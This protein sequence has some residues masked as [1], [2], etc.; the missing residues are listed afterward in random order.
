MNKKG[1]DV[2][3]ILLGCYL[4]FVGVCLWIQV[5]KEKPSNEQLMT[6]IAVILIITG[7]IYAYFYLRK[8]FSFSFLRKKDSDI[9]T[10]ESEPELNSAAGIC[11]K[12]YIMKNVE[13]TNGSSDSAEAERRENP[14]GEKNS[15]TIRMG[16]DIN[17]V[18]TLISDETAPMQ[19]AAAF[20]SAPEKSERAARTGGIKKFRFVKEKRVIEKIE[21][22]WIVADGEGE[23]EIIEGTA[24][25]VDT[26][27][28]E[29]F[30][31]LAGEKVTEPCK[32]KEQAAKALE[33]EAADIKEKKAREQKAEAPEMNEPKA[34]EREAKKTA[35][36]EQKEDK[37]EADYE[38]R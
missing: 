27:N 31:T 38:E 14:D 24:E 20:D 5:S 29:I 25:D 17:A 2:F 19:T 15:D 9:Q 34:E 18:K 23:E 16:A 35:A 3:R 22:L 36:A 26:E 7:V 4:W 8:V 30:D 28:M 11:R 13:L 10:E 33:S 37:I 12:K 6:V 32:Q 21:D 1:G